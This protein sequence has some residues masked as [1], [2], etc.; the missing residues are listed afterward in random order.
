MAIYV[1]YVYSQIKETV[2]TIYEEPTRPVYIS[3]DP[4]ATPIP[5]KPVSIEDKDSF[6]VLMLGVDQR[7]NDPG[8]S[9]TIVI[10][11]VN[12]S[13]NSILMFNI[14]RDTRTEIIG[15]GTTDKINHAYAFGGVD[16]SLQT[17]EHFLDYRIDYYV[18]VN[19]ESFSKIIDLLGGVKVDNPFAFESVGH[20]F[21]QGQLELN[22]EDALLYSR[23]RYEDPR[24]DLGRN[25]RQRDIIVSLLDH[26]AN[27]QNMTKIQSI[28]DQ[29]GSGV[30]TNVT[31]D[32]M[33][34]FAT[35]YRS[36]IGHVD[37]VEIKG[38]GK[39]IDKIWYYIVQPEEVEHIHNM[40]KE[41]QQAK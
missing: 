11:S 26:S 30:K 15:H 9:D 35:K 36:V 20:A 3:K 17:I 28:L 33:K 7:E 29:V 37:T 41:H 22:G 13:T 32:E 23:M 5:T 16:M 40:L 14:P 27:I 2:H 18:K 1:A 24:G 39:T 34:T 21:P 31:F 4:E 10:L 8:R 38:S 19:M 12:P 25:S 6:T